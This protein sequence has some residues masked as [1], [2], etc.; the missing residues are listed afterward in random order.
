MHRR[1]LVATSWKAVQAPP[2]FQER[3]PLPW[4]PEEIQGEESILHRWI[5][6]GTVLNVFFS[7]VAISDCFWSCYLVLYMQGVYLSCGTFDKLV[8][9]PVNILL[10]KCTN[11]LI[12]Y[13][14]CIYLYV[15]KCQQFFQ[16]FLF[17]CLKLFLYQDFVLY[18]LVHG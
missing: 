18:I 12:H 13:V 10:I 3:Q 6:Q 4:V 16:C 15:W 2:D 14:L 17:V 11:F 7:R 1:Y 9:I 8:Y 5:T